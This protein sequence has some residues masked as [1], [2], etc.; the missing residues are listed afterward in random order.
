VIG[1]TL[2]DDPLNELADA[3]LNPVENAL[4]G[5][6]HVESSAVGTGEEPGSG[7][8]GLTNYPNPFDGYTVIA[9]ELPCDGKVTLEVRNT[10]GSL[11]TVLLSDVL[12]PGGEHSLVFDTYSLSQGVYTATLRFNANGDEKVRTI[13]IVRNK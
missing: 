10:L 13:K 6:E 9:Y 8:F 7:A 5:I 1:F 2:A 4:L 3:F 11:V 12:Q